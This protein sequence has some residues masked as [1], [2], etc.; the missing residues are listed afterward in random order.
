MKARYATLADAIYRRVDWRWAQNGSE[1]V[2]QGWKPEC[3]FLHYG[4]EGYNEAII[5]TSWASDR[6]R[7]RWNRPPFAA[8]D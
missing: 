6:R 1:T 2:S 7:T 4:W 5:L 8:G 3:G